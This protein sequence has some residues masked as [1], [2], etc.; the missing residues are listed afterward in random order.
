MSPFCTLNRIHQVFLQ[1]T[2]SLINKINRHAYLISLLII[3]QKTKET[4]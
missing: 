4:I 1:L 3:I 2:V